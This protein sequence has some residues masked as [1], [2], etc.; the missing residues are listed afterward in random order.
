[1][2]EVK[3]AINKILQWKELKWSLAS[4]YIDFPVTISIEFCFALSQ[5]HAV[6]TV[7]CNVGGPLSQLP[8]CFC[9]KLMSETAQSV[10]V[11]GQ[12]MWLIVFKKRVL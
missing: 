11:L 4:M 7:P 9:Y 6:F 10:P 5:A 2:L 8:V 1:M 3:R 12:N